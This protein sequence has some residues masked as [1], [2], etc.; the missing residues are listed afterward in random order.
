MSCDEATKLR[1]KNKERG[2]F[3]WDLLRGQL[4]AFGI[5]ALFV[6]VAVAVA[7]G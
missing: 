3:T 7:L 4:I 2:E 5:G 6:L 1:T